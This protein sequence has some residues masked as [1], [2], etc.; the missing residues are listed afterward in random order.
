MRK[1]LLFLAFG[2]L[3][4]EALDERNIGC[5]VFNNLKKAFDTVDHQKQNW[6]IMRFFEFPVTGLNDNVKP[7]VFIN[8]SSVNILAKSPPGWRKEINGF[9]IFSKTEMK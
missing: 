6:I 8:G 3:F 5:G 9:A 4:Q 2:S 1:I 7:V